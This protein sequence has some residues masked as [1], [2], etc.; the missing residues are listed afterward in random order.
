VKEPQHEFAVFLV[1]NY[2]HEAETPLGI[3]AREFAAVLPSSGDRA[4]LLAA[5]EAHAAEWD[6][7]LASWMPAC[8]SVAWRVF[9]PTC[10]EPGCQ[11]PPCD[12]MSYC[13]EHVL[14]ELL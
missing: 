4:T 10:I 8:F 12:E 2:A 7:E 14:A 9:Q 1:Q 3:F 6:G 5:V 11:Q 13:G